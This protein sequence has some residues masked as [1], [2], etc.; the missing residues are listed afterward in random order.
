MWREGEDEWVQAERCCLCSCVNQLHLGLES[1]ED[2]VGVGIE[3]DGR[4]AQGGVEDLIG[5]RDLRVLLVGEELTTVI[6]DGVG[7]VLECVAS[8][9]ENDTL[10]PADLA[11]G[12]EFLESCEGDG[13]G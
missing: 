7:G 8:E 12:D 13:G 4:L 6:V 10:F 3:N 1:A 2:G 11:L 9:D 5:A